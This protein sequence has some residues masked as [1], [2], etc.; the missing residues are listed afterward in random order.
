MKHL[1]LLLSLGVASCGQRADKSSHSRTDAVASASQEMSG[2]SL[3][4]QERLKP[5]LAQL[6]EKGGTKVLRLEIGPREVVMQAEDPSNAGSVV[7]LHYRDGKVSEAEH[8]TLRGKGQLAD[9]LF[10]LEDVKLASLPELARLAVERVDPESGSVELVLVRRSLPESDD[11]RLRVY[12]KSPRQS[13]YV[14][15]DDS[16]SPL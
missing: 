12:V 9:N 10:D 5:A 7:E 2:P 13:G 3:F 6:R 4:S 15:A 8:A 16:L 1:A 14:D 11:V